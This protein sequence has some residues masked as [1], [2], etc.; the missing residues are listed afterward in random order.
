MTP[1]A[2]IEESISKSN[3][4]KVKVDQV[5]VVMRAITQ[6]VGGIK[7]LVDEINRGSQEQSHGIE[8]VT[9]AT[10]Q[11]E[12]VTQQAAASA[13]E[14]ASAAEE[15]SAQ[16]ETLKAVVSRLTLMVGGASGR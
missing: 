6:E 8:Q 4:G 15:L 7:T 11:M 10:A 12:Q 16:S 3:N 2:L 5:A 9:R 1:R 13:E 14:A